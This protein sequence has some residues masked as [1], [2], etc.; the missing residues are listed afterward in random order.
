[1]ETIKNSDTVAFI[2]EEG[3]IDV[4]NSTMSALSATKTIQQEMEGEAEK[5]G[6][7]TPNDVV[8]Y[9]KNMRQNKL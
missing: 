5:A 9:I 7:N 3:K 8:A 1:M 6:F 2:E 4:L